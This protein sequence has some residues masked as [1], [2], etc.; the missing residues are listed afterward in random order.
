MHVMYDTKERLIED[1]KTIGQTIID[2]AEEIV[3][4]WSDVYSYAIVGQISV[5]SVPQLTW[6][7]QA[8]VVRTKHQARVV[9]SKDGEE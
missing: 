9:G 7:K 3:G 1:V 5:D 4:D 2:K 8:H 6:T